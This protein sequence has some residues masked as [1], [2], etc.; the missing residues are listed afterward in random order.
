MLTERLAQKHKISSIMCNHETK[1]W[2][3]LS[4]ALSLRITYLGKQSSKMSHQ[5]SLKT[6]GGDITLIPPKMNKICPNDSFCVIPWRVHCPRNIDTSEMGVY[7]L[8][9]FWNLF[10]HL[11]LSQ[12]CRPHTMSVLPSTTP[13]MPKGRTSAL[14]LRIE[15]KILHLK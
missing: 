12:E 7:H 6:A 11:S 8:L 13:E 9:A 14:S 5:S 3:T 1:Q 2:S 15:L 10:R 4:N